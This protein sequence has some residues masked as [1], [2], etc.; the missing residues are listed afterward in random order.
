MNFWEEKSIPYSW[1]PKNTEQQWSG[2]DQLQNKDPN[3]QIPITYK[4]NAQGFRTYDLLNLNDDKVDLALGC[5]Q[6][7]GIGLPVE[8]TWPYLLEKETKIKTLNLGLGGASTDTVAR[9]LTN[10]SGLININSV[11]I[12]WPSYNRFEYFNTNTIEEILPST[13]TLEYVWNMNQNN[14]LQRFFKNQK[15]VHLLQKI[16]NFNLNELYYDTTDWRIRG[17]LARDQIHSGYKS[18]SNLVKLFLT[19][20]G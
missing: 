13:A 17:D 18:N 12:L 1:Y 15:I 6:T 19:K 11:Y 16:Q 2:T 4:F 14:S 8:M 5:S 20:N 9:I 3:W 10:V 7:A